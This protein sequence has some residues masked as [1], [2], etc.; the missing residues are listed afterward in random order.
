MK[1]SLYI[2]FVLFL[3]ARPGFQR[4]CFLLFA[5][6]PNPM[7][8]FGNAIIKSK[9]PWFLGDTI[10]YICLDG[11]VSPASIPITC[12][13]GPVGPIWTGPAGGCSRMYL[14]RKTSEPA[15][16]QTK[17]MKCAPSEDSDQPGRPPSLI[18][19]FAVRLKNAW[20]ISYPLSASEDSDQTGRMPRLIWVFAGRTCHFVGFLVHWLEH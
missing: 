6:C 9:G 15:H 3:S 13:P 12:E 17:K 10:E 14:W 11:F 8:E 16:D 7:P 1:A 20:V 4:F 19:V 5:V 18:R 2:I